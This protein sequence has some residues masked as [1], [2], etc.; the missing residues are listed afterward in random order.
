MYSIFS[1]YKEDIKFPAFLVCN[2]LVIS[3]DVQLSNLDKYLHEHIPSLQISNNFGSKSRIHHRT[4]NT[5]NYTR[6]QIE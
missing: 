2:A 6:F 5:G 1:K 4:K 3:A